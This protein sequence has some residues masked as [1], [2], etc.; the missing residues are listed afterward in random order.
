MQTGMAI[1]LLQWQLLL[2]C[3]FYYCMY[4]NITTV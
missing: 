1:I 4:S 3:Y 2:Y